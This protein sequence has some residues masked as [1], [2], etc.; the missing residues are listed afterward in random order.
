MTPVYLSQ[1]QLQSALGGTLAQAASG[2]IQGKLPG[3]TSDNAA[4][5]GGYFA[6]DAPTQDLHSRLQRL[7]QSTL[8]AAELNAA[9]CL[10]LVAS[11]ALDVSLLEQRLAQSAGQYCVGDTV[12]LA[13]ICLVPQVYNAQRFALDMTPY[14]TIN[15]VYQNCLQLAAFALAAPEQQ[16]DAQ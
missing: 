7:L 6:V 1:L 13:D 12:T 2:Y 15:A 11:T 10:L 16:P 3:L 5:P 4:L 14:P 8:D 9:D